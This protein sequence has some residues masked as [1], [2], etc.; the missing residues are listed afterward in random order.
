L[1]QVNGT[2]VRGLNAP[3]I[4]QLICGPE[5]HRVTLAMLRAGESIA[6]WE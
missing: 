2:A 4:T 6:H 5:G 1:V 3:D